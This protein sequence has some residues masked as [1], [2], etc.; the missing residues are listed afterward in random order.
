MKRV[1]AESMTKL[2]VNAKDGYCVLTLS[3]GP[4]KLAEVHLPMPVLE[5]AAAE[6]LRG[7]D[8]RWKKLP[9]ASPIAWFV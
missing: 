5:R 7:K 2:R 4:G 6:A 9:H 8:Y 3:E 1:R